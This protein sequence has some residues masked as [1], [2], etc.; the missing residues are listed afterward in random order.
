MVAAFLR[1]PD[2]KFDIAGLA[3]AVASLWIVDRENCASTDLELNK[4]PW[5]NLK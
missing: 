1:H 5:I 2:G 3:I 4:R